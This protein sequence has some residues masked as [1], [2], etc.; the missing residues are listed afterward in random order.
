MKFWWQFHVITRS[1]PYNFKKFSNFLLLYLRLQITNHKLC[2]FSNYLICFLMWCLTINYLSKTMQVFQV[3]SHN[4]FSLL[5][6]CSTFPTFLAQTVKKAENHIFILSSKKNKSS[7]TVTSK[8]LSKYDNVQEA[9][10]QAGSETEL[11][12]SFKIWWIL[13]DP[14]LSAN[15]S[16]KNAFRTTQR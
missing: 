12:M 11:P 10:D 14:S 1:L 13:W 7:Y 16:L 2:K 3:P 8:I 15:A 6:L 5:S 4:S 9:L